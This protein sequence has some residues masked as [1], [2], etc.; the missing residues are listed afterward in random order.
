MPPLVPLRSRPA[1][2]APLAPA[3]NTNLRDGEDDFT[4]GAARLEPGERG[5]HPLRRERIR[6]VHHGRE[7]GLDPFFA[8]TQQIDNLGELLSDSQGPLLYH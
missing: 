2:A 7:C 3:R 1:A 6:R 8:F 4:L 5:V